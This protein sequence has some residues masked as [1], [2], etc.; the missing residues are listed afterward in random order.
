MITLQNIITYA[1]LALALLAPCSG[2]TVF[3]MKLLVLRTVC[4]RF[5]LLLGL[6]G[7][8][9]SKPRITFFLSSAACITGWFVRRKAGPAELAILAGTIGCRS[10]LVVGLVAIRR[11]SFTSP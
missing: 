10:G 1:L 6:P 7:C 11:P 4:L 9:H 8:C 2:C 5:N 3:V